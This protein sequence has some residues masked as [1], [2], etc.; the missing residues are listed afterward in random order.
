MKTQALLQKLMDIERALH[1][2]DLLAA[3]QLVLEAQD[4]V[5]HIER[6]M[7]DM[8][9]ERLRRTTHPLTGNFSSRP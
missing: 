5:L 3:H 9:T 7:I 6:E 8:Q 1:H 4:G 2:G